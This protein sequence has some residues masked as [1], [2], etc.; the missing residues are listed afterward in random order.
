MFYEKNTK[1]K[2]KDNVNNYQEVLFNMPSWL[3]SY[4]SD[5]S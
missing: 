1:K 5:E 3:L 2:K 4:I